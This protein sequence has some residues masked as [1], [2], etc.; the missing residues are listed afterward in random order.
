MSSETRSPW[1]GAPAGADILFLLDTDADLDRDLLRRWVEESAPTDAPAHTLC[2]A[3]A[4]AVAGFLAGVRDTDSVWLQ[5]LRIAWL[6]ARRQRERGMM[7]A[8]FGSLAIQPTSWRRRSIAQRHPERV[9]RLLG[10]GALLGDLKREHA[11]RHA[12]TSLVPLADFIVRQAVVALERSER[13]ARGAR[14]KI[15]KLL[16]GDILGNTSFQR[17]LADIA[18]QRDADVAELRRNATG[19]LHEMGALQSPITVDFVTALYR[20]IAAANHDP[21]IDVVA[22][23]VAGVADRLARQPVVFLISHKSMLDTAALSLVLYDA[24]LPLPL[25]FGG[26]NLKTPGFGA[27]ARRAGI[28]FLRRSFQDN[29]V[30]KATFRRY[31]DYLIEKRFSLLWALEGTR[32][33]TGKLLPPRF[34]LFNYVVDSILRTRLYNTVFVP[35]SVAYD[36]IT[37]VEDYAREQQGH[38][39]KPEG[40]AWMVRFFRRGTPHGRIFVRFGD[41]LEFG[42]LASSAELD[43]GLSL[44]RKQE[45]VQSLA[46]QVAVNMNAATPITTSAVVTLILLAGGTRALSLRDVHGLMRIGAALLR[47]RKIELVGAENLKSSDEIERTLRQLEGTGIITEHRDG[48][49]P[50]YAIT[51]D[52]H[53]KAAYYRNTA[54]HHFVLDAIVELSLLGADSEHKPTERFFGEANALR[55]MFK[56]EFYFPRRGEY[57][58]AI[59][60]TAEERFPGWE[61]QLAIDSGAVTTQMSKTAPLLAHAVLRTFVDAYRIVAEHLSLEGD[62]AVT[63]RA[64]LATDCL[65]FGRQLR[66]TGR[67]FSAE[68]V[69]KTLFETAFRLADYRDLLGGSRSTERAAWFEELAALAKRLDRI[70]G[71]T[72]AQDDERRSERRQHG[73]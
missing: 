14:Y 5:P 20:Q 26:I 31:I 4:A 29:A 35:V 61:Q 18:Q 39:K 49:E 52:Q 55:E 37:E 45:L 60:R 21:D 48:M 28:I 65:R 22:E 36:Q 66:L 38:S 58:D 42:E 53:L 8:I 62:R 54:I 7:G 73:Q 40:I 6:P 69:S 3:N 11:E 25:T 63:D 44:D 10:D 67:V 27:L 9:R 1:I 51:E 46:F 57:E 12:E 24:D 59:R 17:Q 34:G 33:R 30:Y 56:F 72:L 68:S 47:R 32:S 71:M 70:L 41:G 13:L 23:E 2:A 19:Y 15:A 16:T 43:D 64:S 50:L